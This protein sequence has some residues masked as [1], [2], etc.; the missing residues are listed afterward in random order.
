MYNYRTPLSPT[1]NFNNYDQKIVN[2]SLSKNYNYSAK[3]N[4]SCYFLD[5]G[6]TYNDDQYHDRNFGEI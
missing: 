6:N 3:S 1:H 4:K 2:S 5:Y